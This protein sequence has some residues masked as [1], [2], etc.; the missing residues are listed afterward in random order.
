MLVRPAAIALFLLTI[1]AA[2]AGCQAPLT[3]FTAAGAAAEVAREERL[4]SVPSPDSARAHARA[5]GAVPHVAGTPAQQATAA[6]VL[7]RM[8][9][10]G[11][12]T[13]RTDF[14]VY[15]PHPD[16]I[17]VERVL[18]SRVRLV[19]EEPPIPGDPTTRQRP[20]RAM[21]GTGGRG[22][23]TAPVVYV[24]YG[25]AADYRL[26]DSIG[27]SVKGKVVLARYGRSF[28]GIKVREAEARGAVAV[29]LY[30]DPADDG[31]VR[32]DVY[33][34]GPMRHP[35]AV[36]R[37]SVF[38]GEG[39]PTTPGWPSVDGARRIPL[40]STAVVRIPVV[41]I[42]YRNATRFLEPLRGP[43][44]PAQSWQGGL[45]F[46]YHVGADPGVT[47]RV[48][49]WQP[50]GA[51][52]LRTATNTFGTIRGGE[53]PDEMIIIGA[54]RDA[55]GPGARDNVSGV[56]TVLEAARAWGAAVAAG[57]RPNRTL[58]FATWDAEEWGLVGSTEWSELMRDSLL[59]G[60]VAYLNQDDPASGRDFGAAATGSLHAFLREAT[61]AV[62]QP[63]ESI[64]VHDAW[65]R[66]D[67]TPDTADVRLGDLGGGSDHAPFYNGLG[68]PAAGYGFGG[69]GGA[70]HSAYDTYTY[71]ERFGD[72]GYLA[73]AAGARLSAVMLARLADADVVPLD[74]VGYASRLV[75][76][77]G[78][79]RRAAADRKI[80]LRS[81][82]LDAALADF[83]RSADA[84]G[85][86]R[87]SAL[88]RNTAVPFRAANAELRQVERDLT[89][90]TGL[91]G[92]PLLW[93]IVFS[94][95]RDDGY[96][97]V[98]FPGV[99]EAIRDRDAA[100]AATETHD[101]AVRFAAAA[102]RL[103]AATAALGR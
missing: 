27:V 11:L 42:G 88:A 59:A 89:R 46:R 1:A 34:A 40:D 70:Y 68:I 66:R 98:A 16:S 80:E 47:A 52:A 50:T 83:M 13:S 9:S 29:L 39:D 44:I 49:V 62:Q 96:A 23:V 30:S 8:A 15:L 102:A 6:Y 77:I 17:V 92:R 97:T 61:R 63:G 99:A 57:H 85:R 33:P 43:D 74:Y 10:W 58:I 94:S 75:G 4:L 38:N 69:P 20:W 76:P 72:R 45:P 86:A 12:D 82:S 3:G 19:L 93:N 41:P 35:D 51:R 64:S 54:H 65:R 48:A 28:R 60:A 53:F 84:F 71:Q 87:D 73:H 21:N 32:G 55:W 91:V 37:G 95:D 31:F 100:R 56:T 7:G 90:R 22:D 14:R 78:D 67:A 101:L 24:N 25:L 2:R 36:Q 5:L 79:L 81:D 26:L 103:R 18:P